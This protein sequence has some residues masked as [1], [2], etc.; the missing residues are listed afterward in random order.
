MVIDVSGTTHYLV[1][2]DK[3]DRVTLKSGELVVERNGWVRG[4]G[5][6]SQNFDKGYLWI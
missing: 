3:E 5:I 1:V 4:G 2:S 6:D